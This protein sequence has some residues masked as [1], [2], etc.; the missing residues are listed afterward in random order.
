LESQIILVLGS[1][2]TKGLILPMP[3][4][5]EKIKNKN[6]TLSEQVQISTEKI[7][8]RGKIDLPNAQIHDRSLS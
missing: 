6:T 1:K 7:V 5:V 8:E 4:G 2:T 3:V